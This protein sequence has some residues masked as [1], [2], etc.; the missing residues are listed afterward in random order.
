M[1]RGSGDRCRRGV[2][3]VFDTN[4]PRRDDALVRTTI[5]LPDETYRLVK[6]VP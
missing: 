5:D 1:R 6:L 3:R 2:A 4:A